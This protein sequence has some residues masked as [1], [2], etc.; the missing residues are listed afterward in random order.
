MI[1]FK[2]SLEHFLFF[3]VCFEFGPYP[4]CC[5]RGGGVYDLYNQLPP[6]DDQEVL[7]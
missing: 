4:I 1:N 5:H 7:A 6:G 3:K 2:P